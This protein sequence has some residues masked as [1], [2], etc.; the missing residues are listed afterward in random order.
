M[1]PPPGPTTPVSSR[2]T[3]GT[4][5]TQGAPDG[6]S[7]RRTGLQSAGSSWLARQ[8][9]KDLRSSRFLLIPWRVSR[10]A[11]GETKQGLR[12]GALG[13]TRVPRTL[14]LG[15][16][17]P[18][19]LPGPPGS[20]DRQLEKSSRGRWARGVSRLP[21]AERTRGS[22]AQHG[23][24]RGDPAQLESPRELSGQA[25]LWPAP[26]TQDVDTS[27]RSPAQKACPLW[28]GGSRPAA[29]QSPA[30]SAAVEAS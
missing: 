26:Q 2:L 28:S 3:A 10:G 1:G 8:I 22:Q 18:L 19:P 12:G 25:V 14:W 29:R 15:A 30:P 9:Q 20:L 17:A 21:S 6:G 13:E 23:T 5:E 4:L 7:S 16:R 11:A 27:V 24:S